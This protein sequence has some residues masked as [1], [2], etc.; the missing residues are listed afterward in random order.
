[1]RKKL[2]VFS[3]AGLPVLALV[4]Y[5]AFATGWWVATR[6][7]SGA[8]AEQP[9]QTPADA[10]EIANLFAEADKDGNGMLG[11]C[12]FSRDGTNVANG[13]IASGTCGPECF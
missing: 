2:I 12:P 6:K 13:W 1:M 5:A 10:K 4:A 11:I 7:A 3:A 9:V 8:A